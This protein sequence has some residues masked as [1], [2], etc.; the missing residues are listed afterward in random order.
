MGQNVFLLP[1]ISVS[2]T[3]PPTN[4]GLVAWF[5]MAIKSDY[6]RFYTSP[7]LIL[8]LA[9][10]ALSLDCSPEGG[11]RRCYISEPCGRLPGSTQF[12]V[13]SCTLSLPVILPITYGACFFSCTL[14]GSLTFWLHQ[15]CF[16]CICFF[17]AF[18]PDLTTLEIGLLRCL[19]LREPKYIVTHRRILEEWVT[20]SH[21]CADIRVCLM[22]R[23]VCVSIYISSISINFTCL[24]PTIYSLPPP[25]RKVEVI[26]SWPSSCYFTACYLTKVSSF[27]EVCQNTSF[28]VPEL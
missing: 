28:L 18:F 9:R 13:G 12:D 15:L 11:R 7:Q 5:T 21:W 6:F 16:S 20:Y 14:I 19:E 4:Q 2:S 25:E 23:C 24:T 26:Y 8:V 10:V 27:F 3:S 1:T 17:P 22:C